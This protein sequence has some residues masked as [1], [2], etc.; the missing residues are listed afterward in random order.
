MEARNGSLVNA[1]YKKGKTK[2]HD[3]SKAKFR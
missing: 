3:Y 1:K 2:R